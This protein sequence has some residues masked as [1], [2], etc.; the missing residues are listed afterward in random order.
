MRS[1][2]LFFV[3]LL[4]G[5]CQSS[6]TCDHGYTISAASKTG[7]R[8]SQDPGC[9]ECCQ[10]TR[11]GGCLRYSLSDGAARTGAEY[12]QASVTDT[13]CPASCAACAACSVQAEEDLC[14]LLAMPRACDCARV[15]PIN[16]ACHE[17]ESCA[18]YC[19]IY[20]G[21]TGLCP[22]Q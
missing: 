13:P 12:N 9:A 5:A 16:D 17:R 22:A 21:L 3:L 14:G 11:D 19:L 4:L 2:S 7:C 20:K 8:S 6:P 10:T 18:C 15:L 1:I